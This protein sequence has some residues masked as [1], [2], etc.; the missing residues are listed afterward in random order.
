MNHA[1]T[2]FEKKNLNNIVTT[3]QLLFKDFL[4]YTIAFLHLQTIAA[5]LQSK[6]ILNS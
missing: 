5:L 6:A 4:S 3:S 1:A 2:V